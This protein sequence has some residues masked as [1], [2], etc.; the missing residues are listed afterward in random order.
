M[1]LYVT[2]VGS[3]LT[4]GISS[5]R[6]RA[7]STSSFCPTKKDEGD[8]MSA[9]GGEERKKATLAQAYIITEKVTASGSIASRCRM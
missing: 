3:S 9:Q 4:N 2:S 8:G 5:I 6:L 7:R 1:E